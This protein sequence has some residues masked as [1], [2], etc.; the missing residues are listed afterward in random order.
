MRESTMSHSKATARHVMS[1]G[2]TLFLAVR[3]FTL[4]RAGIFATATFEVVRVNGERYP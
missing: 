1:L 2:W 3:S 4:T